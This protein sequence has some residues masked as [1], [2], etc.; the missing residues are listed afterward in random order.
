MAE[1]YIDVPLKCAHCGQEMMTENL[2][3]GLKIY[4][5]VCNI[6]ENEKIDKLEESIKELIRENDTL[7]E[8]LYSIKGGK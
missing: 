4:K 8:I 7:K 2:L 5:C 3:R 6:F 1:I